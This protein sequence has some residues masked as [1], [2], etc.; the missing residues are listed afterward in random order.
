MSQLLYITLKV[1]PYKVHKK[2][3]SHVHI[4]ADKTR[5]RYCSIDEIPNHTITLQTRNGLNSHLTETPMP[6]TI[7]YPIIGLTFP[8]SRLHSQ[9]KVA[10]FQ[11]LQGFFSCPCKENFF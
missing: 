9:L 7:S 3:I 6:P 11:G 5:T 4:N 1:V 2:K 10:I 8:K